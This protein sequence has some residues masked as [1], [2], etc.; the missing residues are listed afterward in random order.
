MRV[1][2]RVRC[3]VGAAITWTEHISL[4]GLHELRR[5]YL[6]KDFCFDFTWSTMSPTCCIDPTLFGF[7]SMIHGILR[8]SRQTH[9]SGSIPQ[10]PWPEFYPFSFP[11]ATRLAPLISDS[12]SFCLC[13]FL[14]SCPFPLEGPISWEFPQA[15]NRKAG[16]H[17]HPPLTGVHPET[18]PE[19]AASKILMRL[20]SSPT[21]LATIVF[22]VRVL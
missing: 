16:T 22:L 18:W 7:L 2:V 14:G 10:L 13:Q 17:S 19:K 9:T 11:S 4:C 3:E 1:S 12:T 6:G 5:I 20:S 15:G 21:P 8:S